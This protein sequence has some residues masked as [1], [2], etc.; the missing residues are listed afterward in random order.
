MK[1]AAMVNR[2]PAFEEEINGEVIIINPRF[3]YRKLRF[4]APFLMNGTNKY[5]LIIMG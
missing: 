1:F 4:R 3:F 2:S 5:W